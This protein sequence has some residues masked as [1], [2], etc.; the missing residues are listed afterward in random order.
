MT[1]VSWLLSLSD[2][3][4]ALGAADPDV[5]MQSTAAKKAISMKILFVT[6]LG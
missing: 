4:I 6:K 2:S 1:I 3:V 5:T